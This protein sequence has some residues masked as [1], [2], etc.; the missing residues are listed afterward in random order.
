MSQPA[1][2]DVSHTFISDQANA[3][4]FPGTA[5]DTEFNNIA[6]VTDQIRANMALIQRDDGA[7]ANGSV[8][9]NSLSP[10]LQ[11]A[12]LQPLTVWAAGTHYAV[13]Q[14]VIINSTLYQ[15]A[16]GHTA[17]VFATDLTAG[18]WTKLADLTIL[19]GTTSAT[20]N[21]VLAGPSSGGPAAPAFRALVAADLPAPTSTT[22]GGVKS[23]AAVTHN[24][25]TAITTAGGVTQAQPT[26]SDIAGLQT[27]AGSGSA[28][29]LTAG[30]VP[31]ARMPALTG[32]V[33]TSAGAVATTLAANSVT[34]AKAAQMAANTIK[35][36]NTGSLANALDLTVAQTQAMIGAGTLQFT[37]VGV[38]FNSGN[39][40][41]LIVLSLP[42]GFTRFRF[43]EAT[44]SNA[45]HTLIT[46]TCG[47]FTAAATGGVALVTAG[48]TITV[49]ATADAAANNEQILAPTTAANTTS[50]VAASL[51]T[52]N[53]LYFRVATA[54]GAAATGDVT[55]L[56]RPLP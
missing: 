56:I 45:N 42:T 22:L 44:I 30:T 31:A 5:L 12:G 14:C 8:T 11:T 46:A 16:I 10:T 24:F 52:A 13:P 18:D 26:T 53:T 41:N 29:D 40:D 33:T 2:Y 36:N 21:F 48:T 32:D 19:S 37:A 28:S 34:N 38:N 27:I 54:E 25:L 1:E 15:C 6:T 17:S 7:L 50:F 43:I 49:S 4:W 23:L 39:S 3:S 9:F 47:V 20:A 35:G 55:L 51:S